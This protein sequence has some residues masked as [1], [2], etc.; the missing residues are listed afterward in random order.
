MVGLSV[1]IWVFPAWSDESTIEQQKSY[2]LKCINNEIEKY[3]CKVQFTTSRSKKLQ[4]YGEEAALRTVYLSR[5]RETLVQ[6]MA[7][8]KVSMRPHTVH[9][10]L[11]QRWNQQS[12]VAQ[13]KKE[14]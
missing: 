10:Y 1:G 8:Q 5:N 3:S 13:A 7:A 4:D 12:S 11:M 14:P 6:E 9:Q 2:Y